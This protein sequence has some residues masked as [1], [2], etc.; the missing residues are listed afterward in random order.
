MNRI[1]QIIPKQGFEVVR[2]LIG[3][4]LKVELD[5]QKSLQNLPNEN[6]IYVGRSTPFNQSEE[7][8]INVTID[9]A[10][11]SDKNAR[12]SSGETRFH[13]DV[14]TRAAQTENNQGGYLSTSL[15]D[16]YLGMIR[17]ILEDHHYN[18]LGF[19][20]GVIMSTSVDGFENYEP[21][22]N[23]D[24]AFVKMSRLTYS[25][26]IN[27]EQSVWSGLNINSIFTDVILNDTEFG[28]Q[29]ENLNN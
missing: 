18:T 7:L 5:H 11:Y 22:G 2:D 26:K 20:N 12:T 8:M 21:Q 4:I 6:N 15:R 19:E 14:M 23:Q 29:Y 16:K 3:A 27:E 10:S 25:V 28:Y 17:F 24:A 1:T 13:I 9:S